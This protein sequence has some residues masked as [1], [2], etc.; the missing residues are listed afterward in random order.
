LGLQ[1]IIAADVNDRKKADLHPREI[2]QI[3]SDIDIF[4]LFSSAT[5]QIPLGREHAGIELRTV[6]TLALT[7]RRSNHLDG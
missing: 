1:N 3:F 4:S 2:S 5:S 7:A 6:E